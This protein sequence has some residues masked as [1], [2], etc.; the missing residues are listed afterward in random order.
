MFKPKRKQIMQAKS[1]I[2][3]SEKIL[4]GTIYKEKD[5]MRWV[6]FGCTGY[7]LQA[8]REN[9]SYLHKKWGSQKLTC[10]HLAAFNGKVDLCSA[11]IQIG[12]E[13]N[14]QDSFGE[15]PLIDSL[16]FAIYEGKLELTE[17]LIL[18]GADPNIKDLNG[19]TSLG[20]LIEINQRMTASGETDI[21][22]LVSSYK[23]LANKASNF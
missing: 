14:C 11:L 18:K 10:M 7:V 4:D 9:P 21:S 16:Y 22:D 12:A 5:F 17:L 8:I 20:R 23:Q 13:V 1:E 19:N 3:V 15:T 6:S 2:G